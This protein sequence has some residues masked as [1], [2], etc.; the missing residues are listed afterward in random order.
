MNK[1]KVT[2]LFRKHLEEIDYPRR[3][4]PVLR[5]VSELRTFMIEGLD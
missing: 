2:L 1:G 4:T 3:D 5:G